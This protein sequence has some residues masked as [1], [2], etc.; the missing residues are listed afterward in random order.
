[1]SLLAILVSIPLGDILS[2]IPRGEQD[3]PKPYSES[4]RLPGKAPPAA[5]NLHGAWKLQYSEDDAQIEDFNGELIVN[6]VVQFEADGTYRL[7]YTARWGNPPGKSIDARGVTV[8]ELG[9]YKLSG[10]MLIFDP[11]QVTRTDFEKSKPAGS[12]GLANE[13]HLLVVHWEPKRLHLA[14][15]CAPYQVDPICKNW[16]IENAW[17]TFKGPSRKLLGH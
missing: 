13:K 6:L 16:Q 8:D 14:G 15:R 17:F 1:M 10:D 2:K 12:V 9:T 5:G 11:E 3:P 4:T 7:Q